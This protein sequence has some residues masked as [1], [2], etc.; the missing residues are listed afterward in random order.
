MAQKL[1]VLS[2]VIA[3]CVGLQTPVHAE[4]LTLSVWC[5][6]EPMVYQED[7]HPV[8][9]DTAAKRILEDAR[10]FFS[11]MIYG[12]KFSYTPYDR[13]RGVAD[14]FELTPLAEI[15]W[16]DP[17][18]RILEIEKRGNKMYGRVSYHMADYQLARRTS[19]G[20]NT[21]PFASGRGEEILLKGIEAKLLSFKE[22]VKQAVREYARK[23][24]FN[25]PKEI[26]GEVLL[27]AEPKV[28]IDSGAYSTSV[29]IKL[30]IKELI[31]YSIY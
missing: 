22:S 6:L 29:R 20:S 25:K 4:R 11:A 16:G 2:I 1:A 13:G 18:L 19:W 27:W 3:L 31:P 9:A 14:S 24:V 21:I 10:V 7:E 17:K 5:E 8:S 15:R 28:L 12:Y 23:R 30:F 26:R